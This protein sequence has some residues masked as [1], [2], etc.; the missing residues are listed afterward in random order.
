MG[1]YLFDA[2]VG[3]PSV[4]AWI[5]KP[6][7]MP[8]NEI[9]EILEEDN[10]REAGYIIMPTTYESNIKGPFVLSVSSENE[11]SLTEM[12]EHA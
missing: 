10:A 12:V 11:F 3:K 5:R 9:E 4:E 8:L 7:F 6:E 1:V 2:A